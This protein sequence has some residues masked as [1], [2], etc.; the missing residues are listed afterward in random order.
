MGRHVFRL[1][2]RAGRLRD[3]QR[4]GMH[5][6]VDQG[7]PRFERQR[8]KGCLG[9]AGRARRQPAQS[10]QQRL[11]HRHHNDRSR[12]RRGHAPRLVGSRPLR[13]SGRDGFGRPRR[14][15]PDKPPGIP[16]RDR[17]QRRR[18]RQRRHARRLGN[19]QLPR[20]VRSVRCVRRPRLRRPCQPGGVPERDGSLRRGF[21][22]RRPVRRGRSQHP[23]HRSARL[24]QRRRRVFRQ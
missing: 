19:H 15:R 10:Q 22:R 23:R 7:V 20:S 12:C 6:R 5:E 18:H 4:A 24:R 8:S 17:P 13:R 9:G 1:H 3:H 2:G 21:G 14:R 16:E 11:R